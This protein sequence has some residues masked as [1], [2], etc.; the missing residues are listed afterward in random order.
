[1]TQQLGKGKF[2]FVDPVSNIKG[3]SC[4]VYRKII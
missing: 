1:M 4:F 3:F 2:K